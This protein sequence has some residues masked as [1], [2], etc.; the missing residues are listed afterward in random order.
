MINLHLVLSF[1]RHAVESP[2]GI[3]LIHVFYLN[4]PEDTD[5]KTQ[6][7]MAGRMM[8]GEAAVGAGRTI[9]KQ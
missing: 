6:K 3:R 7:W 4:K 8:D 1:L 9:I 2:R 5:K